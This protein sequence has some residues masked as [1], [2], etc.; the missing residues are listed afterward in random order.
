MSIVQI[1]FTIETVSFG[2]FKQTTF[3]SNILS[4]S[5]QMIAFPPQFYDIGLQ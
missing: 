3:T 2:C 1:L 4:L 5:S